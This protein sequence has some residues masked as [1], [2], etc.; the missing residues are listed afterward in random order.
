MNRKGVA[1]FLTNYLDG[2]SHIK[3]LN[4]N[5]PWGSGKTFFLDNW[6]AQLSTERVCVK[7]NAWECDYSGDA[8]ISLAASIREQISELSGGAAKADESIK[9]FTEAASKAIVAATPAL[10]K[11]IL[12]KFTG[13]DF[14]IIS[15][16]IDQDS[17]S[18]AAEKAVESLISKN[19]K[20]IDSAKSFKANLSELLIW[21]SNEKGANIKE[22]SAYIFIDELDRCRPTFAIELLERIKHFFDIDNCLFIIATDT[23]QLTHS[24]KAIYGAGF[25][26]DRYIKRFFDAEFT[27]D[28]SDISLWIKTHSPDFSK[29][30]ISDLGILAEPFRGGITYFNGQPTAPSENAILAGELKL[31]ISQI[32]LLSIA[33]TF[34]AKLREIEKIFKHIDALSRNTSGTF[35]LFWAAYLCFLKSEDSRLYETAINGDYDEAINQLAKKFPAKDLYLG[36]GN[37]NIHSVFRKY[38]STFRG[39]QKQAQLKANELNKHQ[40][41]ACETAIVIDF[42]KNFHLLE[43]YPALVS[44]AHRID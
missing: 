33:S 17:M 15:E 22:K 2:N 1:A 31:D 29:I 8:F 27:L 35:H 32:I 26:A 42:S 13:I 25:A 24:V 12:K 3:V 39:G 16:N 7:F 5:S 21:A 11:G 23:Q 4:I 38:L 18:D 19:R 40:S 14:G 43:K 30:E 41:N 10:A 9:N 28:N 20:T 34:N 36:D 6:K 44:L 37:I